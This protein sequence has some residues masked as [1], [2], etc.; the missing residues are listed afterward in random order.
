MNDEQLHLFEGSP[1]HLTL[2]LSVTKHQLAS[3]RRGAFKRLGELNEKIDMLQKKIEVL[4][5]I[6]EGHREGD[7]PISWR[8]END[9]ATK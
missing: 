4:S 6:I 1:T 7:L 8:H 5:A 3:V 2:E 9:M